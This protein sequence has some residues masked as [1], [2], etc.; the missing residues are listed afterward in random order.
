MKCLGY[1]LSGIIKGHF[2]RYFELTMGYLMEVSKTPRKICSSLQMILQLTG[3]TWH[4]TQDRDKASRKQRFCIASTWV[5]LKVTEKV[6]ISWET[7]IGIYP[8]QSL[9]R[10]GRSDDWFDTT[11]LFFPSCQSLTDAN[12]LDYMEIAT[13]K[14]REGLSS[15]SFPSGL[16]FL[17]LVLERRYIVMASLGFTSSSLPNLW[18]NESSSGCTTHQER[19]GSIGFFLVRILLLSR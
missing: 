18:N 14:W 4:A 9:G 10:T 15:H 7:G 12:S 6:Q 8:W 2:H 5:E 16:I 1:S 19:R 3:W 13:E 17:T 11:T